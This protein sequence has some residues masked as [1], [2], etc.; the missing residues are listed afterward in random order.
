MIARITLDYA[1]QKKISALERGPWLALREAIPALDMP[2][3]P[4]DKEKRPSWWGAQKILINLAEEGHVLIR[5]GYE[6]TVHS[7]SGT[8]AA[9][10]G[11]DE[12]GNKYVLHVSV[13][14]VGLL[15]VDEVEVLEDCCTDILQDKLNKGWRIIAVCPPNGVRRPDYVMGRSKGREP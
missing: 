6:F 12:R 4:E 3:W 8:Y 15:S 11:E 13:P 1:T 2:D 10:A 14:N 7:F 5:A 9:R